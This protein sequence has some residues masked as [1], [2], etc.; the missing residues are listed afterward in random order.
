MESAFCCGIQ[1]LFTVVRGFG[2]TPHPRC[3]CQGWGG[4][5][6]PGCP[7]DGRV[8]ERGGFGAS[9]GVVAGGHGPASSAGLWG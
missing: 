3:L 7:L 4:V 8:D 1:C 9:E 6:H 2:C 5:G